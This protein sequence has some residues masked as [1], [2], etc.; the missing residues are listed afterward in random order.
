MLPGPFHPMQGW[1]NT[2]L[3]AHLRLSPLG[4]GMVAGKR[5]RASLIL[6]GPM[7]QHFFANHQ[8]TEH[9]LKKMDHL[10]RPG[11]AAQLTVDQHPVK[12]SVY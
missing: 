5:P 2:V 6:V 3:L 11:Q 8:L 1:T 12:V 7:R 10:T 4:G 9:V